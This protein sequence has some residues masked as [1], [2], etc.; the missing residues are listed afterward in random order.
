[1]EK[2]TIEVLDKSLGYSPIEVMFNPTEYSTSVSTI[3]GGEDKKDSDKTKGQPP[4][5]SSLN[6][7]SFTGTKIGD[8][9]LSLFFDTYELG[10]DVRK[11]GP[12]QIAKLLFPEIKGKSAGR[13]PLCRFSW[14]GFGYV[15]VIT[16]VKQSYTMFLPDG[17]PVRARLNVTFKYVETEDKERLKKLGVSD[18]RKSRVIKH[19]DRLDLL[20]MDEL[21]DPSLWPVIAKSNNIDDPLN[22]PSDEDIGRTII[23]PHQEH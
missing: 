6:I 22:F 20:A 10:K 2:A 21:K 19:G 13:P 8:L 15:G 1:M 23:I 18:S 3:W 11:Y 12:A 5:I 4:K 14:G 17:T 9:N 7:A 16:D